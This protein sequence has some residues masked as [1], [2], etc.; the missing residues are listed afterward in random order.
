MKKPKVFLRA[1]G[2]TQIGMGHFVRTLALGDILKNH[3]YCIYVIRQPTV[4]QKNEI[5][6]VCEEL[7]ELP[8]DPSHFELFLKLLEGDEIVVLD[9]YFFSSDYQKRIKEKGSKLVC[10]D[11]L[12][13]KTYYADLVINHEPGIDSSFYTAQ[14]YTKFALG[15]EYAL[16]RPAFQENR[17]APRVIS[18]IKTVFLCLGGAD[19]ENITQE[20][21]KMIVELNYFYKII[22]A[23]GEAYKYYQRLRDFI[24]EIPEIA[25]YHSVDQ[26]KMRDLFRMADAAVV[27]MSTL[28]IEALS[29]NCLV[30]GGYIEE[31]QRV[32]YENASGDSRIIRIGNIRKL[33]EKRIK[34]ELE[35]IE[36]NLPL[37]I[38][39]K[40]GSKQGVL[41]E[42]IA[43]L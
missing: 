41:I 25:H 24:S 22:V 1:D 32:T 27:P 8:D 7:I 34:K 31:N 39:N 29:Q 13:D 33:S 35:R 6:K 10:I 14:P 30:F 11:D 12:Y 5:E 19:K 28:H 23:T 26:Y 3:F 20:L 43:S 4:N 36:E 9:N 17:Q 21:A 38:N 37:E 2:G 40:I 15:H 16:I 42:L 18:T